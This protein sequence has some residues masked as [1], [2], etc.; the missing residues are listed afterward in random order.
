MADISIKGLHK[1]YPGSTELA[2]NDVSLE[3]EEG[4]FMV[5]LGPSGCGKTTLLRMVAGLDFPDQGSISIGGRDVTYL[6]PQ[7]RNLS[8]VFQS[9]AVFPHR[10]V[11]TNI[12]F[13]LVMKKLAREEIQRKVDWAADLLQLTPYLDR[14]P[15]HLSGGQRQR[16]AVARAIV[17]DA[18]VLLMDEP[19]SNLDAL[20]RLDFRA[21]LK[22]I[23]QQLGS[24]TLYVTHDQVEA[25]SLSDRVAVMKKGQIAQLGNP[26]TVY[27]EPADR[28]VGGFIGSPPMNFMDGRV[29][30]EGDLELGGQS[31]AAPEFLARTAAR[32][33]GLPVMVGIRA[34][35]IS[36]T[37]RGAEG[38]L[39]ATVEVVEPLGHAT[40][41]TAGLGGQTIKVQV[42][43][44]VR[45][46]PGDQVGL[47]FDPAAIR[48]FDTETQLGLTA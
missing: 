47:R 3:V 27:E 43:S 11:R 22:K 12:A 40:L 28:F 30:E 5:L 16:V 29:S 1:T 24:T 32:S 8:M 13:G 41:L 25:M 35:N 21:E 33:G 48:F 37:E 6:P 44:A 9:Y 4:E 15:A 34:E 2:T 26:I 38:T 42:P 23:V 17:M 20:L 36:I 18:D 45:V 10:K 46:S 14:Y 39:D 7:E 19:L 31:T